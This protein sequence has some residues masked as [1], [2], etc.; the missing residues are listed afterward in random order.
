M[1]QVISSSQLQDTPTQI[2]HLAAACHTHLEVVVLGAV[3]A[4][5][6]GVGAGAGPSCVLGRSSV[7]WPGCLG[8]SYLVFEKGAAPPDTISK[9]SRQ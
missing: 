5:G 3:G 6:G 4:A 8:P 2:S 9:L 1:L 7:A